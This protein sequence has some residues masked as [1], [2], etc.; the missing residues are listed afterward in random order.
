M[1]ARDPCFWKRSWAPETSGWRKQKI[2]LKF[3]RDFATLHILMLYDTREILM[4]IIGSLPADRVHWTGR[5]RV[6]D[7]IPFIVLEYLHSRESIIIEFEYSSRY[8][9]TCTTADTGWVHMWFS[10]VF[11]LFWGQERHRKI[12][13]NK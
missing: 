6:I 8:S 7:V 12:I 3:E 1:I 11:E 5:D 13:D 2:P 4:V 10:E 9:G